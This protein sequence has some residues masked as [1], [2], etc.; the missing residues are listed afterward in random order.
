MR[1]ENLEV[2]QRTFNR[3]RGQNL[4]TDAVQTA[5]GV[6]VVVA[7]ELLVMQELPEAPDIATNLSNHAA[8]ALGIAIAVH[9]ASR[10]VRTFRNR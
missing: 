8:T 6:G 4:A 1:P 10:F 7:S 3:T 5:L 2:P 9:G